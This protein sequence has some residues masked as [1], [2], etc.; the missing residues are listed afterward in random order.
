[1]ALQALRVLLARSCAEVDP[2]VE[3]KV[4]EERAAARR[5]RGEEGEGEGEVRRW[6]GRRG[7]S[8][9]RV[10]KE[11]EEGERDAQDDSA[12]DLQVVGHD[13][14][15]DVELRADLGPSVRPS[16]SLDKRR[17]DAE[18]VERGQRG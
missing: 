6:L 5:Q 16:Q 12:D 10:R 8:L 1:M 2:A 7:W 3:D 11:D 13:Q 9:R 15:H 18:T 17:L 4:A 14:K